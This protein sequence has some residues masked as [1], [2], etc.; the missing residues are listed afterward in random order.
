MGLLK[1]N[2]ARTGAVCRHVH[3]AVTAVPQHV[4]DREQIRLWYRLFRARQIHVRHVFSLSFSQRNSLP[5][6]N[7]RRERWELAAGP[8]AGHSSPG[9]RAPPEGTTLVERFDIEPFSD[10]SAK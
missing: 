4:V 9:S 1:T 10:F 3:T 7:K 8:P 2:S 5:R 6:Q